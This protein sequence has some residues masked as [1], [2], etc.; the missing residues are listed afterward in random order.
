MESGNKLQR[1]MDGQ[2]DRR[3]ASW[4]DAKT[5]GGIDGQM[6]EGRKDGYNKWMEKILL[7][8]QMVKGMGG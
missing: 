2:L 6:D 8:G 5:H 1:G 4:R 7:D 3:M